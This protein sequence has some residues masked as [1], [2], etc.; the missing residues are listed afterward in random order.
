MSSA[1]KKQPECYRF[2]IEDRMK[3]WI[4]LNEKRDRLVNELRSTNKRLKEIKNEDAHLMSCV[5]MMEKFDS[6]ESEGLEPEEAAGAVP[7]P[8]KKRKNEDSKPPGKNPG[9]PRVR[10]AR[11]IAAI[12]KKPIDKSLQTDASGK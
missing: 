8:A 4:E 12:E 11:S 2:S 7:P 6:K 10:L 9:G 1:D 5:G 3:E